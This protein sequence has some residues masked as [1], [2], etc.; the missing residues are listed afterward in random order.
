MILV[1]R[2]KI[3]GRPKMG[4]TLEDHLKSWAGADAARADVAAVVSAIARAAVE[5]AELVAAGPLAGGMAAIVGTN[6]DGDAQKALDVRADELFLTAVRGAP[7]ALYASE[8]RSG[9]V[10]LDPTQRLAVAIDPL[11]GS[12]N[13]DT[14]VSLGTIFGVLPALADAAGGAAATFRQ[15]GARQE[16]SG[17]VIYGPHTALVLTVGRGVQFYTLDR[18]EGVFRLTREEVTIPTGKR[19]YAINASN[20]R[21]WD[22]EI[23]GYIEELV[24]GADGPRGQDFN[25]RWIA[26]LVA[27]AYRI[28]V[29]GGIFLYPRDARPGYERGRLRLVYEANPVALIVEQAGGAACDG[30]RRILDIEPQELHERVPLIFGARDK[31]ARVEDRIAGRVPHD[32]PPLF[33][34]RGLFRI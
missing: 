33:G 12:S 1:C 14:N 17:F 15:P 8:E 27:E 16:A 26:S 3:R 11:D 21:H 25:M 13:I 23:R 19:E 7:V 5:L 4:P 10:T 32:Q 2:P 28:L 9:P 29:R 20:H 34:R 30:E 24:A 22:P 31:L 18:R 6:E